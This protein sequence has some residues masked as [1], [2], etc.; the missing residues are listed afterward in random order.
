MQI[1]AEAE[2]G[3]MMEKPFAIT[4]DVGSSLANKTGSWRTE[5][6]ST[7]TGCR[8]A[9]TPVPRARTSRHWLYRAE[10]GEDGYERAWRKLMEDNPFPAD[11]GEGCYPPCETSCNRGQL[12]EA[13]G[14]D[15]I[16]RF[17]GDEAI[18]RAGRRRSRA[19]RRASGC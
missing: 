10:A 15:S 16:E 5:R 8:R 19:S 18:R 9:T 1:L 4:L 6:P 7:S 17:L 12:D 13:V 2:R 11:D 3:P 14:I